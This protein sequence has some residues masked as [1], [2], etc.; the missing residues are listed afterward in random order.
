MKQIGMTLMYIADAFEYEAES[1]EKNK[2]ISRREVEQ[3][4]IVGVSV[5]KRKK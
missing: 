4:T 1:Q 5:G 2:E 3:N